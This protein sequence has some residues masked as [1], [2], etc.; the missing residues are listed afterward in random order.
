MTLIRT[1][2]LLALVVAAHG[3]ASAQT[4]PVRPV[5]LV[6]PNP[7][8][9]AM[10]ILARVYAPHLEKMWGQPVIVDY[11]AG[12]GTAI[13]M[14][15][16]ARSEPDGHTIGL[17]A[18]PMV[19]LPA[20]RKLP[21][22]TLKDLAPVT[23]TAAGSLMVVAAPALKANTLAEVIDFARRNPGKLTY[24]TPGA[25]SSM[26]LAGE[27]INQEAGID[28]LHVPFKGGA[29]AYPEVMAGRVDLM[30]DTTFAVYRFVQAGKMRAIAVTGAK[31]DPSAP[32]VATVAETFPAFGEVLSIHGIVVSG[33]TPR[34]LVERLNADF[35]K[36]LA[37]PE[38]RKRMDELG[39]QIVGNTADEFAAFIR[40]ELARWARVAKAANIKLD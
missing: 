15:F 32:Q 5:N 26:H 29:Q 12:A 14:E 38:V 39:L 6:V 11:K 24:A 2:G 20:L 33:R 1:L 18:T 25:G 37:E 28:L 3:L 22:D 23:M 40:S 21:Y 35:R 19:I 9:G 30:L 31:R 34:A 13:G 36:L 17:V 16:V 27:L 10:D 4:F 8:G 7:P